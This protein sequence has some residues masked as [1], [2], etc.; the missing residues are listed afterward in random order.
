MNLK[1][2]DHYRKEELSSIKEWLASNYDSSV[3]SVSFLLHV[4]HNFV[5]PPYEEISENEYNSAVSKLDLSIPAVVV[6]E[7]ELL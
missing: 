4:D 5:L 7:T 6:H 3:K 2:L 1:V